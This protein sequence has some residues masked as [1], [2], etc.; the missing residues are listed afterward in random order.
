M[1]PEPEHGVVISCRGVSKTFVMHL[2]DGA[3]LPVVKNAAFGV[4]SVNVSC[5][6]A[7]GMGKSSLSR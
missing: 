7:S 6:P 5:C 2:R 4:R 1:K 3:R